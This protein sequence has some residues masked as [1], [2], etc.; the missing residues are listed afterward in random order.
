MRHDRARLAQQRD[1]RIVDVPAMRRKQSRT[2]KP[3]PREK[4]RRAH[5]VMPLHEIDF[6]AALRQMDR[7]AEIVFLGE[8]ADGLQQ[9]R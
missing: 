4:C 1:V 9:L 5:A 3:V 7:V 8:G 6:G 2:E